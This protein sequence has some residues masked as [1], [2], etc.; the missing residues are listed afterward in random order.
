M[1]EDVLTIVAP[2]ESVPLVRPL[3]AQDDA[4]LLGVSSTRRKLKGLVMGAPPDRGLIDQ[5]VERAELPSH[6]SWQTPV[7]GLGD[8]D[9]EVPRFV[10]DDGRGVLPLF[11]A[12]V[13]QHGRSAGTRE[14]QG[15]SVPSRLKVVP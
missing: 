10:A 2:S 14:A 13:R 9:V 7:L 6:G 11:V 12:H 15:A 3:V 8:V 5:C 1:T 4:D